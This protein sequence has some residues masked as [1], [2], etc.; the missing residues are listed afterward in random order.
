MTNNQ[1]PTYANLKDDT[2]FNQIFPD[3]KVPI[4]SL[5]PTVPNEN[6]PPCYVINHQF[7]AKKQ[8]TELA[9]LLHEHREDCTSLE[10]AIQAV[11]RGLPIQHIWFS[12]GTTTDFGHFMNLVDNA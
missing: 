7:L 8:I 10:M 3:K 11:E 9:S 12:G 6:A 4:I 5:I 2:P 1:A